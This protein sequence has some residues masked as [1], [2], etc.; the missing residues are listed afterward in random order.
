MR[1]RNGK[2]KKTLECCVRVSPSVSYKV[3]AG[4]CTASVLSSE[5][6]FARACQALPL[7]PRAASQPN[8][9]AVQG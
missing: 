9:A 7:S 5:P 1:C 3:G 4:S 2:R 6:G 8:A